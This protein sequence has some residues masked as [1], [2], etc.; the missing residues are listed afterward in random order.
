MRQKLLQLFILIILGCLLTTIFTWPFLPNITSFYSDMGDYPTN[1]FFLWYNQLSLATG[2]ILDPNQYFNSFQFYP[3]PYSVAYNEFLFIP[4]LIFSPIYWI[5]HQLVFS[6]NFYIFLTFV[7]SFISSFYCINYL[8]KNERVPYFVSKYASFIGALVYTFNPM[9]FAHFPNHVNLM[10]RYFLPPLLLYGYLFF[11]KPETKTSLLFFLFF[12][13]NALTSF[14]FMFFSNFAL[15]TYLS[16]FFLLNFYKR[17]YAYFLS[18]LKNSLFFILFIP[19]LAAFY[20]PYFNFVQKEK[21]AYDLQLLWSYS[22]TLEDYLSPLSNN[23]LYKNLLPTNRTEKIPGGGYADISEEHTLFIN[24]I[25]LVLIILSLF[26]FIRS[27]FGRHKKENYSRLLL[28]VSFILVIVTTILAFGP[29]LRLNSSQSTNIKMPFNYLIQWLPIF[30]GT[31]VPSR[32]Q[33]IFY[34]PFSVLV[35]YGFMIIFRAKKHYVIPIL[36]L[37]T[38]LLIGE[39]FNNFKFNS[40]S[41]VLREKAYIEQ[42]FGFL[43][44]KGTL[45][46]PT[47]Y[48]GETAKYLNFGTITHEKMINGYSGYTPPDW[49][50]FMTAYKT[51]LEEEDLK[52]LNIIGIQYII[53]HKDMLSKEQA[54]NLLRNQAI[55]QKGT[56]FDK[57]GIQ[58]I[59]LDNL[60]FDFK[61]CNFD[62]DFDFKLERRTSS[63]NTGFYHLSIENQNDCY[64]TSTLQN[65]YRSKIVYQDD[66][67]TTAYIRMPIV[68]APFEKINIDEEDRNL[69]IEQ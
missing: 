27:L 54:Q 63:A 49:G 13:L 45:H 35:A 55:I 33:F 36:I 61:L 41:T 23:L 59:N 60:V 18:I 38:A 47:L 21:A 2:R 25:P 34:F 24:A 66:I 62:Y 5:S 26:F 19:L 50:S 44:G 67:K 12:T 58:I 37:V 14:H 16:F 11:K 46:F 3:W 4:S 1:G 57:N 8:I 6:V 65:R 68:I 17:N 52:K 64:L 9:T 53:I 31:R 40:T 20:L 43:N 7:L 42:N 56:I 28:F 29:D 10:G 48:L 30:K 39:N 15:A 32:F 22:A 51:S 69:T